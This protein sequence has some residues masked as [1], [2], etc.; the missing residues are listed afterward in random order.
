LPG[1]GLRIRVVEAIEG[2]G[3]KVLLALYLATVAA[4]VIYEVGKWVAT[5]IPTAQ[6]SA[7]AESSALCNRMMV[8]IASYYGKP[9]TIT[10]IAEP[11]DYYNFTYRASQSTH[12]SF[13]LKCSDAFIHAYGSKSSFGDLFEYLMEHQG[14]PVRLTM[15]TDASHGDNGIFTLLSWQKAK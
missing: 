14:T 13:R 11:S 12:Y 6:S 9:Q 15:L 2:F 10:T 1:G 4:F 3:G 5:S 8:D 7:L